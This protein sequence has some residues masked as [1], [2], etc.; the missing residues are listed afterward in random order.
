MP[1]SDFDPERDLCMHGKVNGLDCPACEN[2]PV[3]LAFEIVAAIVVAALIAYIFAH[4]R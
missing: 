4:L 3:N 2:H 1:N